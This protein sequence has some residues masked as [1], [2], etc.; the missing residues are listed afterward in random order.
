MNKSLSVSDERTSVRN[1]L[2]SMQRYV[3]TVH[4][5]TLWALC[6]VA[7]RDTPINALEAKDAAPTC[8]EEWNEVEKKIATTENTI[9]ALVW[10]RAS[11]APLAFVL[12][13]YHRESHSNEQSVACER[14]YQPAALI[15]FSVFRERPMHRTCSV[16]EDS[17]IFVFCVWTSDFSFIL[18][19]FF[20]HVRLTVIGLESTWQKRRNE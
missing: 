2:Q 11:F 20:L 12:F 16:P 8:C 19:L 15:R 13:R 7:E 5:L 10:K 14:A 6:S 17:I 1:S 4:G 9:C 18:L 3:H